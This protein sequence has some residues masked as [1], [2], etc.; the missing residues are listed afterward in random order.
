MQEKEHE[1]V[2]RELTSLME[3]TLRLEDELYRTIVLRTDDR[4]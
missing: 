3:I 4:I 2:K 1:N